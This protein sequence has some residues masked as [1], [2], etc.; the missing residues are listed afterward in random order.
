MLAPEF[1]PTWGGTGTYTVNLLE[2]LPRDIEIHVLTLRRILNGTNVVKPEK[3][4]HFGDNVHIHY[5]FDAKGT[6]AYNAHFQL[7]CLRRFPKLNKEFK[8]DLVHSHHAHMSD[9]LLKLTRLV[10]IPNVITVH[11]TFE[12]MRESILKQN[13]NFDMLDESE[14][15]ILRYYPL[16]KQLEHFSLSRAQVLIAPSEE[17]K[18]SLINSL[19]INPQ[20]VNVIHNG[21][22]TIKFNPQNFSKEDMFQH[23]GRPIVLFVGRFVA[24]KGLGNLVKAMPKVINHVNNVLF[25]FAGQG[26][27]SYLKSQIERYGT[28]NRSYVNMGFR[29]HNKI[30]EVYSLAD[31]F[32]IPSP[33]E[34]CSLSL[35]EA[36]SS[37]KAVIAAN[38]GGNSELIKSY[39][40]GVLFLSQN[41]DDLADKI[42][43]LLDDTALQRRLGI[44]ARKTV[45]DRFSIQSMALETNKIYH[46]ILYNSI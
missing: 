25:V 17:C 22:N 12:W 18:K 20:K 8:F 30:H 42:I 35:L 11:N 37:E 7:Y 19:G 43:Q 10:K 27:F 14:Q 38:V 1:I 4:V 3:F 15:G 34:N 31:V 23:A 32:V 39:Y 24:Q 36:M 33:H 46:K 2:A 21:V 26:D 40:N 9:I 29:E 28:T 13:V 44:Q 5:L 6:F 41:S 16:L 45:I